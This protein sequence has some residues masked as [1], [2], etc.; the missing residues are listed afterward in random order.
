[1]QVI[2]GEIRSITVD[3]LHGLQGHT[4][5]YGTGRGAPMGTFPGHYSIKNEASSPQRQRRRP[6]PTIYATPSSGI[7]TTH[8]R[9]HFLI[10]E[11]PISATPSIC[12]S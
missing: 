12:T 8:A 4:E 1:M 5:K 2:N 11:Q 10:G 6:F 7:P 9:V 3:S